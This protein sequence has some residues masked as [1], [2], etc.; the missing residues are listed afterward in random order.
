MLNEIQAGLTAA[1]VFFAL[2]F[3]AVCL[4]IVVKRACADAFRR[5]KPGDKKA[6]LVFTA[7]LTLYAGAKHVIHPPD[8]GCDEGFSVV[9]IV[10]DYVSSNGVTTV[11]VKFT[12]NGVTTS[13][14]V[15]VRNDEAEEWRELTKIDPSVTIDLPTNILTFVV[16]GNAETNR[17]WWVG[18][19]K[20]SIIVETTGIEI[21]F[22]LATSHSVQIAWTCDDPRATEFSI[23][24]RHRGE[25]TWDTVA[26]TTDTAFEYVGF[27]VGET[28]EWRVIST[29][30]EGE[31]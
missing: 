4:A 3:F 8:A 27:T 13:T 25:A 21:V 24:R 28:W 17:F 22:F 9:E 20:P 23:Q 29:Y 6:I 12:G 1:G 5:M 14:P 11:D 19:D 15:S 10:A 18:V 16:S 7:A 30:M 31:P 26:V 2:V